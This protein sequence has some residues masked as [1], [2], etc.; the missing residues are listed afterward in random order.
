MFK[1]WTARNRNLLL[2]SESVRSPMSERYDGSHCEYSDEEVEKV[3]E[4]ATPP[5]HGF[6]LRVSEEEALRRLAVLN[7]Q[8]AAIE[9]SRKIPPE[10]WTKQI[11]I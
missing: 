7:Q 8:L 5:D 6:S 4:T 10:T 2:F 1:Y 11:T 3:D 9:E